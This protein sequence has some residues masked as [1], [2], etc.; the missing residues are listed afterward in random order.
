LCCATKRGSDCFPPQLVDNVGKKS[1]MW[2][3]VVTT[4]QDARGLGELSKIRDLLHFMLLQ[5]PARCGKLLCR[6]MDGAEGKKENFG[7]SHTI[8]ICVC[9][10]VCRREHCSLLLIC[11]YYYMHPASTQP[12]DMIYGSC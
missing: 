1:L 10:F 7:Y 9:V 2:A 11:V 12:D 8:C 3:L 5:R 6:E 4:L